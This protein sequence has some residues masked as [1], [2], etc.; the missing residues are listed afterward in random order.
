MCARPLP[1][2]NPKSIGFKKCADGR[3]V[4]F[5]IEGMTN[6]YRSTVVD[7]YNER[8]R[9]SK[10][11]VL[12]ITSLDGRRQYTSATSILT[13]DT[14]L[15]RLGETIEISNYDVSEAVMSNGIHY[16]LNRNTAISYIE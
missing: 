9:T 1:N 16:F 7:M 3:I 8:H 4:K 15:Y 12:D 5:R 10:V 6:Q 2:P 14:L 11:T 13:H